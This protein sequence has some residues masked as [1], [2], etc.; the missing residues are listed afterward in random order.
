MEVGLARGNDGQGQRRFEE[1]SFHFHERVRQGYLKL[2]NTHSDSWHT[3]DS[4]LSVPK[5]E[6]FVWALVT[7]YLTAD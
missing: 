3:I 2:A 1:E 7:P 4:T 6:E 5:I